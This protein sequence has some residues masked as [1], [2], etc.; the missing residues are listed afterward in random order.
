MATRSSSDMATRSRSCSRRLGSTRRSAFLRTITQKSL[1]CSL[2]MHLS[3]CGCIIRF[4]KDVKSS[5]AEKFCFS[6]T[7]IL[8]ENLALTLNAENLING[9]IR[10]SWIS[11]PV[12]ALFFL[13]ARCVNADP[14]G[15]FFMKVGQSIS[16]AFQPQPTTDQT[17]K[18][19]TTR[20][21]RRRSEEH[22]S[23]L[24]SPMYLVCRLLL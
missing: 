6:W 12:A 15:D 11:L 10:S 5:F 14:V 17:K 3:C 20:S 19:T 24:Q 2:A 21:S 16:Q 22:T 7:P 13:S 9:L 1:P 4:E 23:E 8:T 18:K